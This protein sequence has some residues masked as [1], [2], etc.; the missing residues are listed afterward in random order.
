MPYSKWRET[1]FM[2][3]EQVQEVICTEYP[4]MKWDISHYNRRFLMADLKN[5]IIEKKKGYS[6]SLMVKGEFE[7]KGPTEKTKISHMHQFRTLNFS[8]LDD[9][10]TG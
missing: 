4:D 9:C 10:V 8:Q 1:K 2:K 6:I 7:R 3:P 5:A